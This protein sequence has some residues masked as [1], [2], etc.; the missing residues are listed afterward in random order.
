MKE[1]RTARS[2][3]SNDEVGSEIGATSF[4]PSLPVVT[5]RTRLR[6]SSNA[7]QGLETRSRCA[8]TEAPTSRSAGR[9]EPG[10]AVRRGNVC[11]FL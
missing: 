2:D 9:Q 1:L 4:A 3:L 7:V 8:R 5:N 11:K 10:R 6:R